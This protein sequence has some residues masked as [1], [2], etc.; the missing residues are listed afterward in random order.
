MILF[1]LQINSRFLIPDFLLLVP[2]LVLSLA[3]LHVMTFPFLS[4]RNPLWILSHQTYIQF[5]FE[6]IPTM[7][8]HVSRSALVRY[9]PPL[10]VSLCC[11]FKP[12]ACSFQFCIFNMLVCVGACVCV[13]ACVRA[14]VRVCVRAR[15]YALRIV[16]T[17]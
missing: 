2:A 10:Q 16:S 6:N 4:G 7:F 14:C 15:V 11:P 9:L 8:P 1:S 13:C 17:D 5:I 12:V 3:P